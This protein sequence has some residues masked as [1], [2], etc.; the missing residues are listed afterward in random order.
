LLNALILQFL[1]MPEAEREA[2]ASRAVAELEVFLGEPVSVPIADPSR[3][4]TNYV[5]KD[6]VAPEPKPKRKGK[7]A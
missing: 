6:I 2:V 4:P 7:G 3:P 5:G 1:R